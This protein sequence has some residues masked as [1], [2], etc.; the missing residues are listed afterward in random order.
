MKGGVGNREEYEKKQFEIKSRIN[1]I[2]SGRKLLVAKFND[3]KLI[4]KKGIL[5]DLFA[6]NYDPYVESEGKDKVVKYDFTKQSFLNHIDN[7]ILT[8]LNETI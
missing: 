7:G 3:D 5:G 2:F 8:I 4:I 1:E 6:F